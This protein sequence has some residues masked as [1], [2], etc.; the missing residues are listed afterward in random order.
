MTNLWYWL[1]LGVYSL[2][3]VLAVC[4]YLLLLRRANRAARDGMNGD[5]LVYLVASLFLASLGA[6][7]LTRI[8]LQLFF[9]FI[10][11]H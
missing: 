1:A 9:M 10:V 4:L 5:V 8:V 6:A 3:F 11:A 7:D 2:I